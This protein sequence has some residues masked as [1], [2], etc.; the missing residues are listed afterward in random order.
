MCRG[1]PFGEAAGGGSTDPAMEQ[2]SPQIGLVGVA[3]LK[4]L[5]PGCMS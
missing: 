2:H 3:G 4:G 5:R 1:S